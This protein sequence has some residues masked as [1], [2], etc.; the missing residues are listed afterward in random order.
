MFWYTLQYL[1]LILYRCL[2][3]TVPTLDSVKENNNFYVF[4][5]NV[6]YMSCWISK[7]SLSEECCSFNEV[8]QQ[9]YVKYFCGII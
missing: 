7:L 2:Q 6:H 8:L 9:M 1:C 3:D 5:N 4:F